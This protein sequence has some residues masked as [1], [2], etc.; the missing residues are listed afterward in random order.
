[1]RLNKEQKYNPEFTRAEKELKK[2]HS[3]W[4]F[5]IMSKLITLQV[6]KYRLNFSIPGLIIETK[7][8]FY[9]DNRGTGAVYKGCR[10]LEKI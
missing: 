8:R 3:I 1:M 10:C 5:D 6:T 4:N 2:D 7:T 9:S